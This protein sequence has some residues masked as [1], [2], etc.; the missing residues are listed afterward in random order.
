VVAVLLGYAL[1][2]EPLGARTVA[3]TFLVLVSVIVI[4][5]TPKKNTSQKPSIREAELAEPR[6]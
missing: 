2:G 5:T 4:T 3:G 1:G 6:R